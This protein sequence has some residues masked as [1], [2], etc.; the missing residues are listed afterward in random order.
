V[1]SVGREAKKTRDCTLRTKN[2]PLE[3]F[4][5][6][7]VREAPMKKTFSSEIIL[8]LAKFRLQTLFAI[9]TV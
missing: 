7:S 6:A 4:D 8:L 1:K 3:S 2:P 5:S 9:R